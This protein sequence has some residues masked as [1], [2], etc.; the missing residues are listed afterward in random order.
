M[1]LLS[2][3]ILWVPGLRHS[4]TEIVMEGSIQSD[5]SDDDVMDE[6]STNKM[7]KAKALKA[8]NHIT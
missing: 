7:S 5:Q 1:S 3:E 8:P 4:E 6:K 2:G